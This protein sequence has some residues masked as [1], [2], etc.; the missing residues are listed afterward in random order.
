MPRSAQVRLSSE[1]TG[2]SGFPPRGQ[3]AAV[4][5]AVRPRALRNRQLLRDEHDLVRVPLVLRFLLR[6]LELPCLGPAISTPPGGV[7][8]A[9][10]HLQRDGDVCNA[11]LV[12][13]PR[14]SLRL[15]L[16]LRYF[17][18]LSRAGFRRQS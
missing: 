9:R 1:R 12:A 2:P 11:Y 13:G 18:G 6:P 14:P 17:V 16:W 3:E 10:S 15:P 7:A 8:D 5:E 4:G